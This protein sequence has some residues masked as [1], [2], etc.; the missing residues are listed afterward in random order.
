MITLLQ[1]AGG[2]QLAVAVAN[3]YVAR[4]LRLD[5]EFA[6]LS[7]LVRDIAK[8]HHAYIIGILLAAAALCL[9]FPGEL[10]EGGPLGAFLSGGLGLF[11]GARLQLQLFRYDPETRRRHRLGDVLFTLAALGLTAIF[12]AALGAAFA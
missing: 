7:P 3:L 1:I 6:R 2:V 12:L 9:V 4:V 5:D 11:W 8:T 10:S